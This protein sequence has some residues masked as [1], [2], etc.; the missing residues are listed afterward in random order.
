MSEETSA[1]GLSPEKIAEFHENGFI[2]IGKLIPDDLIETLQDA[3]DH[4]F[5]AARKRGNFRNL[6][7]ADTD[8]V[9]TGAK[10]STGPAG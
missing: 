1:H 10:P 6:A 4:E 7:M 3:Y 5:Q 9:D 2:K 8:D